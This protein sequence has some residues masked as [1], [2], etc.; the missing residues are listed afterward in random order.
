MLGHRQWLYIVH[1]R[2]CRDDQWG[3]DRELECHGECR[4]YGGGR[5]GWRRGASA[6][7][8]VS[9]SAGGMSETTGMGSAVRGRNVEHQRAARRRAA[10]RIAEVRQALEGLPKG[11]TSST[12][13]TSARGGSVNS[14]GVSN[15]GG[16]SA[17]GGTRVPVAPRAP[18]ARPP[19]ARRHQQRRHSPAGLRCRGPLPAVPWP[20]RLAVAM[21]HQSS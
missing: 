8:G 5:D 11:G 21:R 20:R 18:V 16:S 14:G 4:K 15:T 2:W 3:Y 12:G 7:T 19:P 13:G 17:K 10:S 6:L 9:T 1:V